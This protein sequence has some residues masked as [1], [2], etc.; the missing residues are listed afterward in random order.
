MKIKHFPPAVLG[1]ILFLNSTL[2]QA[3]NRQ[4]VILV[5]S[6]PVLAELD[7]NGNIVKVIK[8]EPAALAGY[9]LVKSEQSIGIPVVPKPKS[10]DT[11]HAPIMIIEKPKVEK[12]GKVASIY[13]FKVSPTIDAEILF[14]A[15]AATLSLD[16]RSQLDNVALDLKANPSDVAVVRS[17]SVNKDSKIHANRVD[18]VRTYLRIKGVDGNRILTECLQGRIDVS[19]IKVHIIRDFLK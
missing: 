10:P 12:D 14:A 1:F 13:D 6:Q 17:L 15:D 18:A 7:A 8:E 19:D 9:D 16:A 5:N 3:Q 2:L 11:E 4:A